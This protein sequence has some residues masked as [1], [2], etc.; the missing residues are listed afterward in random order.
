MGIVIE[1]VLTDEELL[2]FFVVKKVGLL[3]LVDCLR[4][5]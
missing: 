5:I 1:S 3:L 2:R 4:K